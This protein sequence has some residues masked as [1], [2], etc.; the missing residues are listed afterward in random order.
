M[1]VS[2]EIP[3]VCSLCQMVSRWLGA[4]FLLLLEGVCCR[5]GPSTALGP[6]EVVYQAP[7]GLGTMVGTSLLELPVPVKPSHLTFLR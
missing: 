1:K 2:P 7:A 5:R 3:S 4:A 6:V